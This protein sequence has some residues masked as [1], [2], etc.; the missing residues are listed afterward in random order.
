MKNDEGRGDER[1]R[2][3]GREEPLMSSRAK[4]QYMSRG[5]CTERRTLLRNRH[6]NREKDRWR[7]HKG[8]EGDLK[9]EKKGKKKRHGLTGR[10]HEYRGCQEL[11]RGG[12]CDLLK[13][14]HPASRHKHGVWP[15]LG[16]SFVEG[17]LLVFKN[18]A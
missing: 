13:P 17:E 7:N 1:K 10:R 8:M 3:W 9:K 11:A 14:R 4:R 5:E 2:G 15:C 18:A 6:S 12:L 16:Q